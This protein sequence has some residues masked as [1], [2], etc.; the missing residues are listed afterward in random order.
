MAKNNNNEIYELASLVIIGFTAYYILQNPKILTTITNMFTNIKL[1][2][3]SGKNDSSVG[4]SPPSG[5]TGEVLWDSNVHGK[6][7]NGKKRTIDGEEGSQAENGKGLY[8]AASGNPRLHVDGNG[9]ARLEADAGHGRIYVQATN[10]NATLSGEFM[11]EDANIDNTTWKLRNRRD[12]GGSCENRFGGVGGHLERTTVGVKIEKCRNERESGTDK[13]LPKPLSNKKWYGF[14][15]TVKD[16]AGKKGINQIIKVDY[17]D[18]KGLIEVLN[19]TFPNPPAYY[20]D[21][22]TFM[23]GSNFWIRIN[24]ESTGSVAYRNVKLTKA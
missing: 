24:N 19:V 17:K 18:G 6:W 21:E 9:V 12:Q 2:S 1:P 3:V 4:G 13:D 8:T 10:Y 22:A 23:K 14:S 15:F 11:F 16:T 5:I 20:M 7:K